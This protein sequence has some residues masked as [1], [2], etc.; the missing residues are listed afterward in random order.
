MCGRY[1]L[2]A[3]TL[4]LRRE[5]H[6]DE[7]ELPSIHPRYN[8]APLQ[9]VPVVTL[10]KPRQ[11]T[12]A[13]WGL[14]PSWSSDA[15]LAHKL[16]N[17]RVESLEQKKPFAGLLASQRCLIPCDGF[18]EWHQEGRTRVPYFIHDE[19]DR[20]LTMAGLWNRWRSPEGIEVDTFVVLTTAA[21]PALVD[22]H[23][24]MPVFLDTAARSVW[25][26][27]RRETEPLRA[28]LKPW[29]SSRLL[30][31]Q[32]SPYVGKVEHDD[33]RC[34]APASEVQLRLL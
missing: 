27:A 9:A 24:R 26:D 3:S 22:L 30:R 17:A 6:L 15:S 1:V 32:V 19:A 7:H 16:I 31:R 23:D 11:L 10:S 21:S 5:L 12:I 33:E 13:Q 25:L 14:L 28:L 8:V 2:K 34:I 4:D 20:I 18:Y 29:D